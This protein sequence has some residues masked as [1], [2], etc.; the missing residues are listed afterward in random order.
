MEIF[1]VTLLGLCC[2]GLVLVLTRIRAMEA[3]SKRTLTVVNAIHRF[4]T[5][6]PAPSA[7]PIPRQ[8]P[9]PPAP[10]L[11]GDD[12]DAGVTARDLP[13]TRTDDPKRQ[14]GRYPMYRPKPEDK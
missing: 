8:P 3:E 13:V 7:R 11:P 14:F 1:C 10:S 4:Q 9:I 5:G 6:A 12:R 2:A